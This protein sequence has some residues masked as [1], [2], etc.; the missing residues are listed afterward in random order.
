MF[1]EE[2]L[3]NIPDDSSVYYGDYLDIF[4][5]TPEMVLKKLESLNPHKTPG[6]D[7]WHPFLLKQLAAQLALPLSI[8]FQKSLR[9]GIVP[10][11]WLNACITAIHKKGDKSVP[12][13]Y[14]PISITSIICK[15]MESLVRDKLVEHMER[16]N[17]FS[18]FQH[19]FVPLG[20]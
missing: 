16:N 8:L 20:A 12:G 1:T 9:E 5:I 6:P 7:G 19:G 11:E 13:N 10:T 4:E 18:T 15:I 14:R 3:D 17:L 2:R